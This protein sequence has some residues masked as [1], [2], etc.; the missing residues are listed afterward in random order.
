MK[1]ILIVD[2]DHA[3]AEMLSEVVKAMGKHPITAANGREGLEKFQK[4]SV[5]LVITD[6]KMPEMDGNVLLKE[7]K[8]IDKDAVVIVLTGY[9]SVDTAVET[10]K[11][12]AYDYLNKPLKVAEIEVV[13]ERALERKSLAKSLAFFKGA[14]WALIISVPIWLILG[15]ILASILR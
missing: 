2:D 13:I 4:H 14:N 11:D 5:D 7:I 10:I 9:P 3:V 12:G 6:L 15:I 1:N 8:R